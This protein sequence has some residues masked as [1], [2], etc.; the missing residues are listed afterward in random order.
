MKLYPVMLRLRG[1]R[2]VVIGGGTVALRKIKDLLECGARVDVV[3]P[4]ADS[5]IVELRASYPDSLTI[6]NRKFK[7]SDLA[8]AL[9]VFSATDDE[10]TNRAV[11]REAQKRNIIINS[12]DDPENCTF[13][14]PSWS[15][16]KGVVVAVSSLG[17]S[18]ALAAR[19]R[20]KME[21][22]IPDS[23]RDTLA[24]LEKT[25]TLLKTATDFE[26]MT[27]G[28]RGLILKQ[29]VGNDDLLEELVKCYA[30][31]TLEYFI[32]DL[33]SKATVSPE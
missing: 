26:R 22:M 29:I 3:A 16:T 25:R 23:I 4:R 9:I 10:I 21:G 24:A 18:P 32:K 30:S 5:S 33:L 11:S 8:G 19:L 17:I 31:D 6:I 20:R 27:S 14:V 13:F 28:Q 12:A 7:K 1:K 2:A 15:D